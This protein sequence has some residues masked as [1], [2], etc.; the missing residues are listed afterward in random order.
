MN[1]HKI[2]FAVAEN[3][4]R[5]NFLWSQ[6]AK[7]AVNKYGVK[8]DFIPGNGPQNSTE[9]NSLLKHYDAV[10]SSWPT[11]MLNDEIL[12]GNDKLKIVGH[13]AGSVA[14]LVSETLYD[15]GIKVTTANGIMAKEVAQWCVMMTLMGSRNL[16]KYASLDNRAKM[17]WNKRMEARSLSNMSVGIWGYGAISK[18]YIKI[19]KSL[20]PNKISVCSEHTSAEKLHEQGIEKV[21]LEKLVSQSDIIVLL[22]G[23]TPQNKGRIDAEMLTT[24][25]DGAVLLNCGRAALIDE[26][27]MIDEL[28][29]KRFTACLDVYHQEPL[30]DN[31][32]LYCMDN[33]IMTPHT[34]G[35]ASVDK[36]I[37]EILKEFKKFF[38]GSPLANEVTRARALTMTSK[39]TMK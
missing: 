22:A 11:P 34:G 33:V 17:S 26:K 18:S 12:A 9:W 27:D 24:I 20:G 25:K 31:S 14:D 6:A 39:V 30:P 10:I 1:N 36:Y 13:A 37:P 2:L 5:F 4:P 19:L 23:M 16:I 29:K 3:H 21:S 32:L 38:S 7:D 28:A 8:I 15:M 35:C